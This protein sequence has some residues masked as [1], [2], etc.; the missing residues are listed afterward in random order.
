MVRAELR[1]G[2]KTISYHQILISVLYWESNT[3]SATDII[4]ANRS[5]AK[6]PANLSPFRLQ[7]KDETLHYVVIV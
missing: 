6:F 4:I 1:L 3:S 7:P 2:M 5:C